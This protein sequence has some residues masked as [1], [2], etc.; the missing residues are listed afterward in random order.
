MNSISHNHDIRMN[1]YRQIKLRLKE[2]GVYLRFLHEDIDSGKSIRAS[3]A[4][5]VDQLLKEATQ[6]LREAGNLLNV[7]TKVDQ[8]S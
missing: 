6:K 3:I 8:N 1:D 5:Q 2:A 7:E 4:T